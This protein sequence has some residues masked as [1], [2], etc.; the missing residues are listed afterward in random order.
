VT[1]PI[2]IPIDS[3]LLPASVRQAGPQ[4][5]QLYTTALQ[6]EQLLVEQLSQQL[7]QTDGSDGSDGSDGTTALYQQMLP[8]AMAQGITDSGGIGLANELYRSLA[9][10]Q[11]ISTQGPTTAPPKGAS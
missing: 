4:A 2:N 6:F 7:Q 1:E 8:G 10:A 5:Q 3:S 9:A 11:G